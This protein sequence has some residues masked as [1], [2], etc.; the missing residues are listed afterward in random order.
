MRRL[1][2]PL[3]VAVLGSS[4]VPVDPAPHVWTLKLLVSN[5]SPDARRSED[6]VVP[7][8]L[9]RKA[10]PGLPLGGIVVTTSEA[11]TLEEDGAAIQTNELASQLDDLDGDGTFDELAFQLDLAPHQ[12]RVVTLAFGDP[13]TLF[14]LRGAYVSRTHA[15]CFGRHGAGWESEL[16]AWTLSFAAR[17]SIKLYGKRRPGL[18]LDAL[19]APE[20][21]AVSEHPAGRELMNSGVSLGIGSVGALSGGAV[22]SPGTAAEKSCRVV[23]DGPVRAIVEVSY[24]GWRVGA[25]VI[26]LISRFTQWGGDRG[27]E[28]R[29]SVGDAPG[30]I[31][32]AAMPRA[33][34]VLSMPSMRPADPGLALAT[35]GPPGRPERSPS[36]GVPDEGRV[37]LAILVPEPSAGASVPGDA[38]NH[39]V[40][41]RLEEGRAAAWYVTAAWDQ[42]GTDAMAGRRNHREVGDAE[43]RLLPQDSLQTPAAFAAELERRRARL[44]KPAGV[45]LLTARGRPEPAPA[46]T[47]RPGLAKSYR[48]AIELIQRAADHTAR[49][50][51]PVLAA[52]ATSSGGRFD[53]PGFLED[54]DNATGAWAVR[55]GYG[56]TGSFWVGELWRLYQKTGS[57]RYRRWAE[58]WNARLLGEE[59]TQN[60]DVGFLNFYS[61]ALAYDLTGEPAYREGVLRACARLEQ[62]YNPLTELV[63]AWE[64]GGDDT[65][66]DTMMNLQVW[67]WAARRTGDPRWRELGLKHALK[68]AQWLVRRDGSVIQ[69]V[70]Y[71]PGDDRQLFGP[72]ADKRAVANAAAPGERVFSHTHQGFAADT[73]WAR[74]TAWGL[75]GF[76]VAYEE[77]RDARLL[78]TA[79]RIAE[80]VIDRLPEDAVPWY[81]LHDEGVHYRNRDTSAAALFACGLLRLSELQSDP[82]QKARYRREGE[83]IVSSLLDRYLTP[84]A[85]GDSTPPGVLRHGCRTRPHDGRLI[86]GEYYLLEALL[87]LDERGIERDPGPSTTAECRP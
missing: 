27:F 58:L 36:S 81:D 55:C 4:A 31:L 32:V 18:R 78:G 71:N 63:A 87:W 43:S 11:R 22:V 24:R 41:L 69:S 77:T 7:L 6:V 68:S 39:L 5:P 29:V 25:Q 70:H 75:Y 44:E 34:D 62:L 9:V 86:Y 66:I 73:A 80:F 53:G 60:H 40:A 1:A 67:W 83:R 45:T 15:R 23:A 33:A 79:E 46:D 17:D 54:G 28:H 59:T 74:G 47:L 84:V 8:A 19:G 16:D 57:A 52:S 56:W 64:V 49:T 26:S 20:R 48:E 14:R 13:E 65:I 3:L 85:A 50:W 2:C 30:V 82:A 42:E 35:W 72:P 38:A 76:T 12:A 37:G 61:S 21:D 10:A 51:E